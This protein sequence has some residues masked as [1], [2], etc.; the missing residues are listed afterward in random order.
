[1]KSIFGYC[2]R[3]MWSAIVRLVTVLAVP[4]AFLTSEGHS[5]PFFWL[6]VLTDVL[7]ILYG[8]VLFELRLKK[9]F[10]TLLMITH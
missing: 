3:V 10:T 5:L 4:A 1:M 7:G 8:V 2:N 9:P 6:V